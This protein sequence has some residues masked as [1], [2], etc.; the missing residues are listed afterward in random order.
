MR[1]GIVA[2]NGLAK[3]TALKFGGITLTRTGI[4]FGRSVSI[5]DWQ[6][7]GKVAASAESG[8]QWWIGDW[9]NYGEGK[10]KW[11]DK[12]AEA[13]EMFD[14]A[15]K[16]L[17]DFKSVCASIE[18]PRRRGNLSFKHH[19]EVAKFEPD[20]QDEW[21][22]IAE[23]EELSAGQLRA[24]IKQGVIAAALRSEFDPQQATIELADAVQWLN[25]QDE[26]DL[27]LTDPPY[28]TDVDDINQFAASWLPLA[29]S[30]VKP[31]GRAYVCIGAYPV[32]IAAYCAVA[33][34]TQILV[35]TYRNT[36]GPSPK[37]QYKLNWQA[38]M[39]YEGTDAPPLDCPI[40]NE[41]FSVQDINAPDGRLGDRYHAWQKPI[42]L[43]EMFI[44]HSTTENAVVLDPFA[45][46]GSFLLAAAR[47]GRLAKGC[48][49]SQEHIAIAQNR[50][51]EVV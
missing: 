26:C 47:L 21:L 48:D 50:G 11:G 8:T 3:Q 12:Y 10:P 14:R 42:E 5:E 31:T 27:L 2:S 36:L 13:V 24:R 25:R 17:S 20:I 28:S 22:D 46:T 19:R 39:Y 32:E 15:Y 34:P 9:L 33:M 29:L 35:W 40:M 6:Q 1:G 37:N 43:A 18:F 49:I 45:C 51:C 7:A 44:R 4:K 38:I 41:Q 16:S 23:D 30:K